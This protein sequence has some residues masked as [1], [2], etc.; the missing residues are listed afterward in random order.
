MWQW[1]IYALFIIVGWYIY[2]F[3]GRIRNAI[4][5][6][7][8]KLVRG[9]IDMIQGKE[10]RPKRKTTQKNGNKPNTVALADFPKGKICSSCHSTVL[11][12][13]SGEMKGFGLCPN[14]QKLESV[15]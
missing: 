11:M 12:P 13:L 5:A 1:F 4:N 2:P 10:A 14:C 15:K 7:I 9:I 6:L 3:D 8:M